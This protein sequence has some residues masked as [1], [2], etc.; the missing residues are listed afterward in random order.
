M[1]ALKFNSIY[2]LLVKVIL[3]R[4]S[5]QLQHF[6]PQPKTCIQM[7][8]QPSVI[9]FHIFEHADGLTANSLAK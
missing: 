7:F 9:L 4:F 5:Y 6:I 1:Q 3:Y 2:N 8:R